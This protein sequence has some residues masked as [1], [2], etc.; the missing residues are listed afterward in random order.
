MF[1]S[2]RRLAAPLAVLVTALSL[3]LPAGAL[4]C[5]SSRDRGLSRAQQAQADRDP[6]F[7]GI[8]RKVH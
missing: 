2:N 1:S 4:A 5:K 3:A 8:G 6:G 7:S